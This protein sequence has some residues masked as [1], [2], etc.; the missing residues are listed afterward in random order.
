METD[1]TAR[2]RTLLGFLFC[3]ESVNNAG[4]PGSSFPQTHM[5]CLP[6]PFSSNWSMSK[7]LLKYW[8]NR[9][10]MIKLIKKYRATECILILKQTEYAKY[11][12]H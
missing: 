7:F 6:N 8:I 12:H 4:E 5:V 9:I 10:D 2:I 3:Q 11:A 1:P